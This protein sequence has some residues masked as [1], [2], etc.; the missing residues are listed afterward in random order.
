MKLPSRAVQEIKKRINDKF[1][2]KSLRVTKNDKFLEKYFEI[3]ETWKVSG[4]V[5]KIKKRMTSFYKNPL[6]Q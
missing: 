1:L 4:E 2:E 6:D 3:T 5:L